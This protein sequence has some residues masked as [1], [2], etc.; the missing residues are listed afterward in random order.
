MKSKKK[1][2][3]IIGCVS[4]FLIGVI[5]FYVL[6]ILHIRNRLYLEDRITG[7]F[8]MTVNGKEYVPDI[9]TVKHNVYGTQRITIDGKKFSIKGGKYGLYDICYVIENKKLAELANDE[10]FKSYSDTTTLWFSY[11]NSNWWNITN[12]NINVDITKEIGGWVV[13]TKTKYTEQKE[14]GTQKED[15]VNIIGYYTGED[16][17][18]QFG[19]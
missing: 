3:I 11:I 14:Y 6:N 10:V 19:L 1:Q 13:S 7:S 16:I 8:S 18:S 17:Q 5:I 12:I 4:F 9:V 15:E 2:A